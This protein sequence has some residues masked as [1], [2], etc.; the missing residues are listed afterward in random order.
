MEKIQEGLQDPGIPK[1]RKD[2]G[3]NLDSQEVVLLVE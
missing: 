3:V 1:L 2:A